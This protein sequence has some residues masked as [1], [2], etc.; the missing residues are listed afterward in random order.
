MQKFNDDIIDNLWKKEWFQFIKETPDKPW[1]F[2]LLS[3]NPN[4][5]WDIVKDNPDVPW[6]FDSLS[7]N[8]MS[9]A[10]AKYIEHLKQSVDIISDWFLDLKTDPS[11]KICQKWM[12]QVQSEYYNTDPWKQ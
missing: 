3:S 12:T 11:S 10:K 8:E 5:T 1:N 2:E 6:D 9:T 7:A 4:I